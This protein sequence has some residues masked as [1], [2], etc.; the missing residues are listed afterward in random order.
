[1]R[2]GYAVNGVAILET[3]LRFAGYSSAAAR[4]AYDELLRRVAAIPG[5]ESAAL[6][7]GLPMDSNSVPIVVDGAAGRT[8]SEVEAAMLAAGPGF[9]DTLRIP[10]LYGRVFDARDRVDTPRVA[11][12]TERMA[13]E[14]FA[15]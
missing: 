6:L 2:V 4:N 13:R 15:P 8:G 9:F 14:Y 3:D 11:V 7:R 5:V 12:I 1:M 10:L